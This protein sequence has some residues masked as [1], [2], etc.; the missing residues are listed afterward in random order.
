MFI[1]LI[2]MLRCPRPH[3]D[4]WLVLAADEVIDRH[5]VRG[6]LGCPVCAAEFP[7]D[8]GE[9]DL[10]LERSPLP[11]PGGAPDESDSG[12]APAEAAMRLAALL[13][14]SDAEGRVALVGAAAA[15]AAELE[16]LTSV[17]VLTVN[18]PA[19]RPWH[20]SAVRCMGPL[21][22]AAASLRGVA[23]GP[24]HHAGGGAVDL[25]ASLHVL[26]AGAR[27][28]AP[29]ALGVPATVRELARDA[30]SWVGE[31]EGGL[32]G[33]VPLGVRRSADDAGR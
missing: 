28:V 4:S 13:N 31:A 1:E 29:A 15:Y 30:V 14:L 21:P 18:G 33:F 8:D 22:L 27:V 23:L 24:E 10:R 5:V 7:I 6:T 3:E 32:S 25:P 12:A 16:R 17:A 2:D 11:A 26:R 20:V 19:E 9:A